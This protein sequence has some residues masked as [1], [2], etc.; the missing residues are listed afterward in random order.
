MTALKLVCRISHDQLSWITNLLRFQSVSSIHRKCENTWKH[1]GVSKSPLLVFQVN[2]FITVRIAGRF[3]ISLAYKWQ[4]ESVCMSLSPPQ[5]AALLQLEVLVCCNCCSTALYQVCS[6]D[7]GTDELSYK[8]C[9]PVLAL[10]AVLQSD[11]ASPSRDLHKLN[12][13]QIYVDVHLLEI[14]PKGT[15]LSMCLDSY[16]CFPLSPSLMI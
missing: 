1:G 8:I 5:G 10:R 6:A 7:L 15:Q 3:A 11:Q 16:L 13:Q 4:H 2:E 12:K 9:F 14:W